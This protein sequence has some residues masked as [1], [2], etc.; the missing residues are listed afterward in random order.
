MTT[1]GYFH[2]HKSYSY[3]YHDNTGLFVFYMMTNLTTAPIMMI[4][5]SMHDLQYLV[6]LH[7]AR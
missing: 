2:G 3:Y 5:V 4:S 6:V 7:V 1:T